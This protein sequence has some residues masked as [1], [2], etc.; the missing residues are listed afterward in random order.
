MI[1][2]Y[3]G[4]TCGDNKDDCVDCMKKYIDRTEVILK[5][6]YRMGY[7]QASKDKLFGIPARPD[8]EFERLLIKSK[9]LQDRNS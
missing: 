2:L 4:C 7:F 3:R 8:D 9:E 1:W 5:N 6:V